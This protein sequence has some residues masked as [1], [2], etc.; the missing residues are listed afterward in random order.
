MPW[1]FSALTEK[2]RFCIIRLVKV[3]ELLVMGE[4]DR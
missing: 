3:N 1:K 2:E 4:A